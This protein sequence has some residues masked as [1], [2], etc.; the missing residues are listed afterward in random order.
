MS[1]SKEK[2]I[3][4]V[5]MVVATLSVTALALGLWMGMP[6]WLLEVLAALAIAGLWVN[7]IVAVLAYLAQRAEHGRKTTEREESECTQNRN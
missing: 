1:R 3:R 2:T 4:L 5:A 6:I 7:A